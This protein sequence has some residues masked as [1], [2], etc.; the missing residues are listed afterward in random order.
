MHPIER[1]PNDLADFR[2]LQIGTQDYIDRLSKTI[3]LYSGRISNALTPFQQLGS[4]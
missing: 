2:F 3:G 1:P 4:N